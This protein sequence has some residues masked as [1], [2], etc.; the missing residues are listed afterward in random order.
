METATL[1]IYTY[2]N[3]RVGSG[4]PVPND[5][6]LHIKISLYII[7]WMQNNIGNNWEGVITDITNLIG[8]I[9]FIWT[10]PIPLNRIKVDHKY[11]WSEHPLLCQYF[12]SRGILKTEASCCIYFRAYR[13]TY[14]TTLYYVVFSPCSIYPSMN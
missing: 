1:E 4:L 12:D 5:P 7:N 13:R 11:S 3:V 8:L 10:K 6:N 14:I 9:Y 2:V